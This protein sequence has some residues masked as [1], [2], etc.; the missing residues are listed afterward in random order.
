MGYTPVFDTVFE[1]SLCGKYPDTAVWLY[2][3]AL[4]DHRGEIDKTPEFISAMTGMPLEDLKLGIQ[5]LSSPDPRSRSPEAEGRRLAL[6][7]SHRDWGWRVVNI[8]KYR[9][10]ASALNQNARQVADGRNA[11]KVRR[12]KERHRE[13]PADTADTGTHTHTQTKKE[14]AREQPEKSSPGKRCPPDCTLDLDYARSL[15]PDID[16]EAEA[17]RF[18]DYEFRVARKDWAATWRNWIRNCKDSGRYARKPKAS[19]WPTKW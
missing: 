11:E 3:L 18:K 10:K 8:E 7:D 15:I 19:E 9:R 2:M 5:H 13:T 1:G 17:G 6:I 16:A 12:Y 4:A 14:E